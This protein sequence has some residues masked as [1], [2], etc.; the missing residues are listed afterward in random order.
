M[1]WQKNREL[2]LLYFYSSGSESDAVED[3]T[4]DEDAESVSSSDPVS[5]TDESSKYS[6]AIS[7]TGG[8]QSGK[9]T[10]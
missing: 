3:D 9:P 2:L 7:L 4:L 6:G 8:S 1:Q 10:L 5:S